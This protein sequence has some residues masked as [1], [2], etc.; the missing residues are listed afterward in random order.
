MAD[1]RGM[2]RKRRLMLAAAAAA[3]ATL[4][5]NIAFVHSRNQDSSNALDMSAH[6]EESDKADVGIGEATT[7]PGATIET[8][9][10]STTVGGNLHTDVIVGGKRIDTPKNGTIHKVYR[11]NGGKTE[12]RIS[13]NSVSSGNN[14]SSS[15]TD[16]TVSTKT[17]SSKSQTKDFS[18]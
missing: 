12:V 3:V 8:K 2:R 9:V 1:Q 10:E 11:S 17:H 5:A 15:I 16:L 14:S 13:S 7:E 4:T 18:P 6:I